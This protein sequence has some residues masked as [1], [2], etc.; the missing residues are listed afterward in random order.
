MKNLYKYYPEIDDNDE[1]LWMV[2]EQQSDQIVAQFFFEEDAAELCKFL[3]KGGGFSGFTPSFILQRVP[4][5]DINKDF[6]AEFA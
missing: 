4:V 2:Y 6:Q 1:L 5:Q 3:E